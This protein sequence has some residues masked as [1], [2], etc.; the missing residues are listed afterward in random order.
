MEANFE[1]SKIFKNN[2]KEEEKCQLKNSILEIK[3]KNLSKINNLK[4]ILEIKPSKNLLIRARKSLIRRQL[5]Q[6]QFGLFSERKSNK[7]NKRNNLDFQSLKYN[8]TNDVKYKTLISLNND[9]KKYNNFVDF[10]IK[11]MEKEKQF[12]IDENK[13]I[14]KE[15][16]NEKIE[17][18]SKFLFHKILKN[19]NSNK[20]VLNN[21]FKDLKKINKSFSRPLK[22]PLAEIPMRYIKNI[23]LF[24]INKRMIGY[25]HFYIGIDKNLN[26]YEIY[27]KLDLFYFNEKK[28]DK[29]DNDE[30]MLM[31]KSMDKALIKKW[32]VLLNYIKN[33][34]IQLDE[35][36]EHEN[37]INQIE[38]Q[39]I[40]Q[41]EEQ[42]INQIEE[43]D[44]NQIEEQ[45]INQ[46]EEHDNNISD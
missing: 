27:D 38:E 8:K 45:N 46:I 9:E 37:E 14:Y 24:K 36:E 44:N 30:I 21:I 33:L 12:N 18:N 20:K 7:R 3:L 29:I 32:F 2:L 35:Q 16:N 17:N 13:K 40:N 23:V 34:N 22:K 19:N 39:N 28:E 25:D 11:K 31:F 42:N 41:I 1:G 26:S 5:I 4:E 10:I 6:K 15:I 43:H